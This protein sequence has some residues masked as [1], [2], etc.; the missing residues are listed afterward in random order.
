MN[1]KKERYLMKLSDITEKKNIFQLFK[2]NITIV[3]LS[4]YGVSFL[5]YYIFYSSFQ[6]PIFNYIGLNDMIFFFLEYV[7]KILSS[8]IIIEFLLFFIYIFLHDFFVFLRLKSTKRRR[9]YYKNLAKNNKKRI[10]EVVEKGFSKSLT[11]FKLTIVSLSIFAIAFFPYKTITIPA[12][13]IYFIYLLE[14]ISKEKLYE[15]LTYFCG[16]IVFTSLFINTIV[17]SYDKR[18][19]KDDTN[20][21]FY[22]NTTY[23]T[24]DKNVSCYNYLGETSTHIF[25]YDIEHKVSKI[26]NKSSI[27]N[28]TIKNSNTIDLI[29]TKLKK[30]NI[31]FKYFSK[32]MKE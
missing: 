28:Y 14:K 29:I 9:T 16:F 10:S 12:F 6:I 31:I 18:F 13:F 1:L 24:T 17:N 4:I 23:I 11:Q 2:E 22:E 26:Y 5:N 25:L 7:F 8:I 27:N 20:I 32:M 21:S 19:Q 15:F 3:A 30:K